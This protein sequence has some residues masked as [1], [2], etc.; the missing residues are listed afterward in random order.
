MHYTEF[1]WEIALQAE[2]EELKTQPHENL[3]LDLGATRNPESSLHSFGR[4]YRDL[5]Y[6]KAAKLSNSQCNS[7]EK[8]SILYYLNYKIRKE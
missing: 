8:L 4:K 7:A 3:G 1:N 2:G 6:P 5:K